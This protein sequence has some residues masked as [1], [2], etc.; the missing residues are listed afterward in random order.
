MHVLQEAAAASR[1]MVSGC[2][3]AIVTV[4]V[5]VDQL[6]LLF[7]FQPVTVT[8]GVLRLHNVTSPLASVSASRVLRVHAVTS[9]PEGT[10]GSS[11]TAH[12]A[13]S[14]LLFGT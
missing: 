10:R 13:T 5:L 6:V 8:P 7:S 14:A 4:C 1:K 9:A 2:H 12:P 3:L 11:L